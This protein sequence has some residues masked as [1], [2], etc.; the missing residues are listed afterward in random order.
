MKI[1]W[2]QHVSFEGLGSIAGW[3]TENGCPVTG[4]RMFAG[5]A[6]P[7]LTDFDLLIIMGGPMSVNDE[8]AHPWLVDEKRLVGRALDSGKMVLGICLGAQLIASAA[9]SRI[10]GNEHLEIGWFPV[11]KTKAADKTKVGQ[12]MADRAEVFHWHGETFDLPRGAVHLA[13]SQ[14]CENQAFCLG[15]GVV[16]LQYHLETTSESASALIQHCRREMV[17]A[18]YV[19]AESE[20]FSQP[21]RFRTLN[22]EMDR[23]LDYFLSI[24]KKRTTAG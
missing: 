16:G 12:A 3:G 4:S 5:D 22:R 15:D 19:Q 11:M 23:L 10:R 9:G 8:G 7:S 14:G 24:H 1:H 2:L 6:L 21:I 20:I 17:K 18:P 13:R